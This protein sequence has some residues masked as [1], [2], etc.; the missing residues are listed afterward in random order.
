MDRLL[1]LAAEYPA[2]RASQLTDIPTEVVRDLALS[3]RTGICVRDTLQG[4]LTYDM[5][6]LWCPM[7]C[8]ISVVLY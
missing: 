7:R 8:E 5:L 4:M 6:V 2:E 3:L 1:Q